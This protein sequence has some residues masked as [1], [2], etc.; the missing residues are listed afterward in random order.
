MPR[1]NCSAGGPA[2]TPNRAV[3][4]LRNRSRTAVPAPAAGRGRRGAAQ[5]LRPEWKPSPN[6]AQ[7][8]SMTHEGA[9]GLFRHAITLS[10]TCLVFCGCV[11]SPGK[12]PLRSETSPPPEYPYPEPQQLSLPRMPPL[13]LFRPNST[14]CAHPLPWLHS[15]P[16]GVYPASLA[17]VLF[18]IEGRV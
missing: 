4:R 7:G 16:D 8:Q 6:Q 3:D 10:I 14:D 11:H 17:S 2:I 18:F 1:A 9:T 13:Q 5:P 12:L 15:K